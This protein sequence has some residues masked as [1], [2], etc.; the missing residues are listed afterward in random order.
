MNKFDTDV[1]RRWCHYMVVQGCA[2]GFD[3]V[4]GIKEFI[5][6]PSRQYSKGT[7]YE[8]I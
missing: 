5:T 4:M 3:T 1:H 7:V 8:K 6:T 2:Y